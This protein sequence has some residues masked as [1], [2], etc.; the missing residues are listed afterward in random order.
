MRDMGRKEG[1]D[2]R[3]T[4][5]GATESGRVKIPRAPTINAM[6]EFTPDNGRPEES[7]FSVE[8]P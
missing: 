2:R 1:G 3:D 6:V 4:I 5:P 7:L 8:S